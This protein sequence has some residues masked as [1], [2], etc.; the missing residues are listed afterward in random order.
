MPSPSASIRS[1]ASEQTAALLRRLAF[2]VTRALKLADPDAVHDLRVAIRRFTHSV[3][4]FTAF[5]PRGEVK[6]V[7]RRLSR[8]MRLAAE[9][10]DRDITLELAQEAGLAP[11]APILLRLASER[12]QMEQQLVDRLKSLQQRE[13]SRKWRKRLGL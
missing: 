7:R 9:V 3:R 2:Q 13:F 12:K 6:K 10:R 4:V 1:Y 8:V 5:L 11:E